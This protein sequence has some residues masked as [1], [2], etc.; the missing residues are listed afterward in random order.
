MGGITAAYGE[1]GSGESSDDE[2]DDEEAE[3]VMPES[4]CGKPYLKPM[5]D[6]ELIP[7][8]PRHARTQNADQCATSDEDEQCA[9]RDPLDLSQHPRD[10]GC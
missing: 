7:R 1:D 2:R 8:I 9:R 5:G 3:R 6:S 10:R 4:P